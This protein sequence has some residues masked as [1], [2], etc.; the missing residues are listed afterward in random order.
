[1][2]AGNWQEVTPKILPG[3]PDNAGQHR[4]VF[5]NLTPASAGTRHVAMINGCACASRFLCS[6]CVCQ[7][8]KPKHVFF[9]R[10]SCTYCDIRSWTDQTWN[11]TVAIPWE[12][13]FSHEYA[14]IWPLVSSPKHL[15]AAASCTHA[16]FLRFAMSDVPDEAVKCSLCQQ[17][18]G[19]QDQDQGGCP[20]F[21]QHWSEREKRKK[22]MI[23]YDT[24]V[25]E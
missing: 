21:I 14:A 10:L 18:F 13:A 8:S 16:L 3:F 15:C 23:W 17:T 2:A 24:L 12:Q 1:M 20:D 4:A 7:D 9:I 19:T 5:L 11:H 6:P 22:R 25:L